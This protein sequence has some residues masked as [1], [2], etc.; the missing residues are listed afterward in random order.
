MLHAFSPREEGCAVM[1]SVKS[2]QRVPGSPPCKLSR[3]A[4]ETDPVRHAFGAFHGAEI[5]RTPCADYEP[6]LLSFSCLI[7]HA[8]LHH[9][10]PNTEIGEARIG[11]Q[12]FDGNPVNFILEEVALQ[13]N[14]SERVF[15]E[16]KECISWEGQGIS[17]VP[18]A[19]EP[20][21]FHVRMRSVSSSC[22]LERRAVR[23]S[24]RR[25]AQCRP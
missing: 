17:R 5:S 22:L 18:A 6:G 23:P 2:H 13:R 15:F 20:S 19:R 12:A 7:V 9:S 14:T 10:S 8:D 11:E 21:S 4:I 1:S 25:Y 24:K 3:L 16:G